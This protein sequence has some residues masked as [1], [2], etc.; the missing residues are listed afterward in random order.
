[1]ISVMVSMCLVQLLVF[2]T[3]GTSSLVNRRHLGDEKDQ[4]NVCWLFSAIKIRCGHTIILFDLFFKEKISITGF[5][6]QQVKLIWY[7]HPGTTRCFY[8]QKKCCQACEPPYQKEWGLRG[9]CRSTNLFWSVLFF[10]PK[11]EF[12]L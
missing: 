7:E 11:F 1:M 12:Y 10:Y 4:H 9:A 2:V 6:V 3:K 8:F 5:Y